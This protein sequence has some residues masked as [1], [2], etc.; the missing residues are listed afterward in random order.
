MRQSEIRKDPIVDRYVIIAPRRGKRPVETREDEAAMT[1]VPASCV[2]C[3]ANVDRQRSLFRVGP[4]RGRWLVKVV[5]NKFPA[6]SL[7]NPRAYGAQE[8]II[9]T[10][11]HS[12]QLDDL[13]VAHVVHVLDTYAQRTRVVTK[14]PKISYVL[15]FKN[16][17][18]SAGASIQHSHSQLFA[19]NFVPPQLARRS[20]YALAYRL[21]TGRCAY[22]DMIRAEEK[23]PRKIFANKH[24][25]VFAPFASANNYEVW[26]LP[27]RHLDNITQLSPVERTALA[28]QLKRVL[29]KIS[30]LHL[31]YNYYF[32]QVIGD[33]DQHLYLKIR[34]RGTVWAGVEIGSGVIINP[35]PPE[36][37]AAYFRS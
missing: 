13:P 24:I 25:S 18:G 11:H 3:P 12:K 37:A 28:V 31:S 1:V 30:D 7:D 10:P 20:E 16:S 33:E 19:T 14:L 4:A 15:I 17:G 29:H 23:S 8:V 9:E 35:M 32:H 22:C 5:A 21:R 36:D 2:F 34:P 26:I 27:R 6:V